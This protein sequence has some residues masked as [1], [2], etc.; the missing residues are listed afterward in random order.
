MGNGSDFTQT[1]KLVGEDDGA[2]NTAF[3]Y[4]YCATNGSADFGNDEVGTGT[5]GNV[6]IVR[7]GDTKIRIDNNI[8]LRTS[9]KADTGYSVDL[10]IASDP[11][12]QVIGDNFESYNTYT[13]ASNYERGV[14]KWDSNDL[15]IGN[16]ALGTGTLRTVEVFGQTIRVESQQAS[17]FRWRNESTGGAS[18]YGYLYQDGGGVAILNNSGFDGSQGG[19]YITTAGH[20]QYAA[21]SKFLSATA[22]TTSL[23]TDGIERLSLSLIHI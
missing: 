5:A 22:T 20:S 1:F 18:Q 14:F 8:N 19:I 12:D 21:G 6:N 23:W 10:G 16:E 7:A 17:V 13:D 11:F 9:L 15:K 3:A 2:G 4:M